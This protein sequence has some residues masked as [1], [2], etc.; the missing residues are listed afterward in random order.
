MAIEIR[1]ATMSINQLGAYA[2]I[3]CLAAGCFAEVQAQ[4]LLLSSR[5]KVSIQDAE[6]LAQQCA[7][8]LT[9]EIELE[10]QDGR[11]TYSVEVEQGPGQGAEVQVDAETGRLVHLEKV[12]ERETISKTT[13]RLGEPEH[14]K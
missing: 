13:E 9:K 7:P 2:L 8:G 4:Q 10:E 1:Y 14:K 12:T 6:K 11:L 3:A 5:I